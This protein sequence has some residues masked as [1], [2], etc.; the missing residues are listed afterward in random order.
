MSK[1]ITESL[2]LKKKL[3]STRDELYNKLVG[4]NAPN[5]TLT[6]RVIYQDWLQNIKDIISIC[7]ERNKF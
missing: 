6:E 3:M 1:G 2:K 7:E 5:L 4:R